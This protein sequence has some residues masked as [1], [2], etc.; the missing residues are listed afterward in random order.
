VL[1]EVLNQPNVKL[2]DGSMLEY[3]LENKGPIQTSRPAS[4]S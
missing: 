3:T 2:Y 1:S 4:G